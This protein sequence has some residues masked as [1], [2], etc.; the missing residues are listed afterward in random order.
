MTNTTFERPFPALTPPQRYHLDVY[1]YVVVENALSRGQVSPL[2][3]AMYRL[4][5]ELLAAA[6]PSTASVRNCRLSSLINS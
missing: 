2:L 3:D 6:D 1:G 5:D 4:R